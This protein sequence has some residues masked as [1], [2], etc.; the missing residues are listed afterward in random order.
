MLHI[1]GKLS[2][3]SLR[4]SRMDGGQGYEKWSV[5]RLKEE[6]RLRSAKTTGR[7][8]ALVER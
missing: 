7:K 4:A 5:E 2:R 3:L 8:S 6:L 1:F